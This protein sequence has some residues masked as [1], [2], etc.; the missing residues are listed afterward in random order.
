MIRHTDHLSLREIL[1]LRKKGE[2][3]IGGHRSN[4]I[5]GTLDCKGAKMWIAKG[6]YVK[7]RVFFKSE[8][9]AI[10]EGYRPCARCMPSR[11]IKW[12]SLQ[13]RKT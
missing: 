11:Y 10:K 1:A 5:Y 4:K 9:E 6:H 13:T 12:K 7:Q 2:V 8:E 3:Q